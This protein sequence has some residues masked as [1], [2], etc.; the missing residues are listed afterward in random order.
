MSRT[1]IR[2]AQRRSDRRNE[3]QHILIDLMSAGILLAIAICADCWRNR[4]SD[5]APQEELCSAK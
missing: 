3:M 1:A 2:K 4:S 5:S